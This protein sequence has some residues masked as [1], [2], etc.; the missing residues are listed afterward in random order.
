MNKCK[1]VEVEAYD[2]GLGLYSL[3]GNLRRWNLIQC[4]L[5]M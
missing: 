2:G 3:S 4:K 1:T 5:S